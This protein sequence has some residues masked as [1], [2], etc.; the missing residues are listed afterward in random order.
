MSCP[1]GVDQWSGCPMP[2]YCISSKGWDSHWDSDT[3]TWVECPNHCDPKCNWETETHCSGVMDESGCRGPDTCI[4]RSLTIT[5]ADGTETWC[6]PHCPMSCNQNE[7]VCPGG[8]RWDGCPNPDFCM[9]KEHWDGCPVHCEPTCDWNNGEMFCYGEWDEGTGC[10][11]P[12]YCSTE[13]NCGA[14]RKQK[15][16]KNQIVHCE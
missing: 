1:G 13:P 10:Y 7:Q 14:A 9:P 12:S 16:H 4:P 15:N 6:M 3:G 8:L 11:G 5:N 2:E